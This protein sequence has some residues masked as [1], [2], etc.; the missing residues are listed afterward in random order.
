VDGDRPWHGATPVSGW[1]N[2]KERIDEQM[3]AE[4]AK[5]GKK[6]EPHR[7]RKESPVGRAEAVSAASFRAPSG[8]RR[9]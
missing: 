8:S 4:L 5:S 9:G 7:K 6:L 1:S 3:R 2:V